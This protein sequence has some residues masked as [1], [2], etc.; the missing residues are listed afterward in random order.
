M[1]IVGDSTDP[2]STKRPNKNPILESTHTF[3]LVII[4]DYPLKP[5]LPTNIS[6][7]NIY[8]IFSLFFTNNILETITKNTDKYVALRGANQLKPS[9]QTRKTP[10]TEI[11]AYLEILIY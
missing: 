9:S 3:K 10:A 4:T 2:Q 11:K 1:A 6:P 5:N 7:V 8:G